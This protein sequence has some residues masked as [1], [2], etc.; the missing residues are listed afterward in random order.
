MKK[1]ISFTVLKIVWI[2]LFA[3]V[4]AGFSYQ[5]VVRNTSGEI[6]ANQTVKF[7][8]SILQNSESGTIKQEIA[9]INARLK[10]FENIFSASVLK[11]K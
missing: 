3:K 6:V 5:A 7:R 2:I 10:N 4:P 11:E 8:I 1:I 9:E